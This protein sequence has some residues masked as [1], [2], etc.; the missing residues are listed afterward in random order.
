MISLLFCAVVTESGNGQQY[1]DA[2]RAQRMFGNL[3][4]FM[5]LHPSLDYVEQFCLRLSIQ[6]VPNSSRIKVTVDFHHLHV[7]G[8]D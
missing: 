6:E 8:L 7:L 4:G 2:L 1:E 3:V 5:S